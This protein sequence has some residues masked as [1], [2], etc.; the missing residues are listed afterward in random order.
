VLLVGLFLAVVT[1]VSGDQNV[2]THARAKIME[3]VI[4]PLVHAHVRIPV[5]VEAPV[6][7]HVTVMVVGA[8][9]PL[10]NALVIKVT[11]EK[12]VRGP[13]CVEVLAPVRPLLGPTK[14]IFSLLAFT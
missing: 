12:I 13:S 1:L 9:R 8:I 7:P 6:R 3:C 11:M 4:P 5:I 14:W 2:K 10:V